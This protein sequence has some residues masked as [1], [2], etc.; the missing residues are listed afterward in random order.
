M[1]RGLS[2]LE[3][4]WARW[5]RTHTHKKKR[6]GGLDT[7]A[8]NDVLWVCMRQPLFK[9]QGCVSECH[10][11]CVCARTTK[12]CTSQWCFHL[13][14]VLSICTL[15][16]SCMLL[17]GIYIWTN[18]QSSKSLKQNI[19][20]WFLCADY[21]IVWL[22]VDHMKEFCPTTFNQY[23]SLLSMCWLFAWDYM[24]SSNASQN[25]S[26]F[27][28]LQSSTMSTTVLLVDFLNNGS[29]SNISSIGFQQI[30]L[31]IGVSVCV[32]IGVCVFTFAYYWFTA[33]LVSKHISTDWHQHT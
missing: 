29:S 6:L 9:C 8:G 4:E 32:R 25:I 1:R 13:D 14:T 11:L 18:N 21:L 33:N 7:V 27:E 30:N 15:H 17:Q 28:F 31:C 3:R 26:H 16:S 22:S 23:S 20:M 5:K 19:C 10:C 12:I 2:I 24:K